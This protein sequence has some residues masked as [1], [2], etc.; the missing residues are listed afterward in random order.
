MES[1]LANLAV[2]KKLEK[3]ILAILCHKPL[4]K[5][6]EQAQIETKWQ[7]LSWQ[8]IPRNPDWLPL[9][10][11]SGP[12]VETEELVKSLGLWHN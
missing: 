6:I 9:K 5:L 12:F 8:F 11:L 7:I 1:Y 3:F 4:N 2:E 10:L